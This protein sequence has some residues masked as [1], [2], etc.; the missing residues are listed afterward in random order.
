M[1]GIM[2]LV[3]LS[4]VLGKYLRNCAPS[5]LSCF[6]ISHLT[7]SVSLSSFV[8]NVLVN[9]DQNEL[10]LLNQSLSFVPASSGLKKRMSSLI[11][12]P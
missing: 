9:A 7:L 10:Q 12:P 1:K 2:N 4:F 8:H 3:V 6:C 11:D 5:S